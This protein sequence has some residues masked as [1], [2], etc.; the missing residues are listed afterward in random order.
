MP[1]LTLE[2]LQRASAYLPI[3]QILM[4]AAYLTPDMLQHQIDHID[5]D[6]GPK[7]VVAVVLVSLLA[8]AAVALRLAC[9]RHM[10]VLISYDDYMIT[11]GLVSRNLT[12][13]AFGIKI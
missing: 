6:Q 1:Q 12:T 7:V 10:R 5:E 8:T 13:K 2:Q 9:R 11:V 3:E 4:A